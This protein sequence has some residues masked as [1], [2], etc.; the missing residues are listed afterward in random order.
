MA[1]ARHAVQSLA[2]KA[3]LCES[4]LRRISS[5]LPAVAYKLLAGRKGCAVR[6]GVRDKMEGVGP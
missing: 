4:R 2:G 5:G 3:R 1:R 6:F